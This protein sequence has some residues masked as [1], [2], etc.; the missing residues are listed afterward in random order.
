MKAYMRFSRHRRA[1]R[2]ERS[3]D[4]EVL[5]GK[6]IWAR[7]RPDGTSELERAIQI[8]RQVGGTHVLYKVG[9]GATYY[10]GSAQA[11]QMIAEAGL[12]PFG[13]TWL[14]LDD[15][16]GEAEVLS[17]ALRDGFRGLVLDTEA[18]CSRKFKEA[19]RLVDAVLGAHLDLRRLYNCSF[20]NISHHRDL[21]YDELNEMCKGGLMP[22]S[23]GTFFAPGNPTPWEEQ[24]RQVIDE[25]TY[26]HYDYWCERWG[27]RPPLYPVLAPYHDEYGAARMSPAEF[28]VWLDHLSAYMP[29]FVS[30]FTA[31]VVDETL[32]PPIRDFSLDE[33]GAPPA[34]QMVW[35]KRP[36]GVV[37]YQEADPGAQRLLAVVYGTA[38]EGLAYRTGLGGS[39][40]L[41]VRLPD[42]RTGWVPEAMV[43]AADPGAPPA[44]P[45]PPSPPL[46]HLTHVWTGREVNYRSRPVVQADTLIG[47]LYPGARLRVL[48]DPVEARAKLGRTGQWLNVQVEPEGPDGWIAAWYVFDRPPG[49]GGPSQPLTYVRVQ[50][51]VGLNVRAAPGANAKRIWR[52][53]DRTVLQVLEDPQEAARKVGLEGQWL[54]VRTPSLHE[55]YVAA[56][57]L[58]ADVPADERRP[59]SDAVLPLGECAWLFGI[60]GVGST[61]TKDFRYLFQGSGKTGWVL[62]TEAIG[63]DPG[64]IGPNDTIRRRL[65]EWPLNGYGVV[66]RLNH[67]YGAG[68]TL[69]NS[70]HYE[71]FA[72]TCARYAELYLKHPELDPGIYTWVITIGNEQNNPREWPYE[73]DSPEPITHE[74]Y[75]RAFNLAYRAI[76]RVLPNSI[77]APGAVDPYNASVGRPLDY[78]RQ[79]LEG[80]EDL[81]GFILHTYTHGPA[82]EYITGLRVFTD[83]PLDPGTE[84]EHYYDFQ[85]Y[86][87]FI[88]AIPPRW[89]DRPIYI[90]E[91]NH[92]TVNADGTPPLGWVNRNTGWVR[93]AYEE[94]HRWNNTPHAQQVRALLLY[95]WQG[96]E[97]AIDDKGGVQEDF[98]MAL[99]NDYRWRR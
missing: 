10:D 93:A 11:A 54:H 35:V 70:R 77:V 50:S 44:L 26:G 2:T 72:A 60:H 96:D 91:T 81:D 55:G 28:Q 53:P 37:L 38:M 36:E 62:F 94:I 90:T 67:G 71:D 61:D 92:W 57:L 95:R 68:G 43:V 49:G 12:V 97:W 45:A 75:A 9:N 16:E 86:R 89:R 30:V 46:G 31:A 59:V 29:S 41:R 80:C 42:G 82:V 79:M 66:I 84:H 73:G 76:K 69:P 5:R 78:F 39:R 85:A 63:H 7:P 25:W 58:S 98:K 1:W 88:E 8:A 64:S 20:P 22:M 87:T 15:P 24:A 65:W 40:W 3:D 23:Y 17:C 99:A 19:R 51:S 32:L 18:P 34:P 27:C 4:P 74:L 33:G 47:R 48:E 14:L 52:V 13:W 21:P 83:P 56:W 6:G